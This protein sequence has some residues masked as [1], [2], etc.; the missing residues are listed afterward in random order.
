MDT[1]EKDLLDL[2]NRCETKLKF[3]YGWQKLPYDRIVKGKGIISTIDLTLQYMNDGNE[4]GKERCQK[5]LRDM[6][7][8]L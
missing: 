6:G 1:M 2:K 3:L 4:E 5:E 7:F 8:Q